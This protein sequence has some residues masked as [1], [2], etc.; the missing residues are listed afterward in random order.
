MYDRLLSPPKH[1]DGEQQCVVGVLFRFLLAGATDGEPFNIFLYVGIV[2]I[3]Q[4]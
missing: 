4:Q 3:H 1:A 2:L